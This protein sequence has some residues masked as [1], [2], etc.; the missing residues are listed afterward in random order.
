MLDSQTLSNGWYPSADY[1]HIRNENESDQIYTSSVFSV[2]SKIIKIEPVFG[3]CIN[4]L[5]LSSYNTPTM[6]VSPENGTPLLLN[7]SLARHL[8]PGA[9]APSSRNCRPIDRRSTGIESLLAVLNRADD[10]HVIRDRNTTAKR[11]V[12]GVRI[13]QF[14]RSALS[15]V[16]PSY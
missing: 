11:M 6:I 5:S 3:A 7:A 12:A 9:F 14:T 10:G 1:F 16:F 4:S 15:H 2:C 13:K 8:R